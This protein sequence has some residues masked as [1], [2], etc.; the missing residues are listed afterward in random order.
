MQTTYF[1]GIDIGTQGARVVLLDQSGIMMG[2][3]E[4]RF[5][6]NNQSREEQSPELWWSSCLTSLRALCSELKSEV[7]LSQVRAIAVTA[8][9]G[10]IIPLDKSNQP[11]H[12]AIMY[13]DPRSAQEAKLCKAAASTSASKGFTAFTA[14]CGLPKMLWFIN[15]YPEKVDQL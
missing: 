7:D 13:S 6:L 10:T 5:S 8:T 3:K 4:E 2:S 1:I 11:L 14:S 15:N 9:S 12:A